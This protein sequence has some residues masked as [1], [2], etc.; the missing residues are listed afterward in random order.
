MLTSI[1]CVSQ[2]FTLPH[3]HLQIYK[4]AD[5]LI[6]DAPDLIFDFLSAEADPACKRNI[7]AIILIY[8]FILYLHFIYLGNAFIMLLNTAPEKATE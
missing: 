8:Q 7:F 6:P 1:L 2:T 4:H 5:N 3:I